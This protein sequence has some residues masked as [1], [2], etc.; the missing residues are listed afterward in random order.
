MD[1]NHN[2][3][4]HEITQR[5]ECH[6]RTERGW[7]REG[8][9]TQRTN[10]PKAVRIMSPPGARYAN[11]RVQKECEK[12]QLPQRKIEPPPQTQRPS[13]HSPRRYVRRVELIP[14]WYRRFYPIALKF[15]HPTLRSKY[16]R[17]RRNRY[18][19]P[20]QQH[21]FNINCIDSPLL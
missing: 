13:V 5:T 1:R 2:G 8:A 20:S 9:G 18:G 16:P 4:R 19:K 14:M 17:Y 7:N 15:R 12:K 10:L 11:S 3:T 21:G 6:P